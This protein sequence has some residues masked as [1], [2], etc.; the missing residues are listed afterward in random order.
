MPKS[1]T[2][3]TERNGVVGKECSKCFQWKTLEE[4]HRKRGGLGGRSV[5][6]KNCYKKHYRANREY[7]SQKHL[8]NKESINER[9]KKY[10]KASREYWIKRYQDNKDRILSLNKQWRKVNQ[11]K[12]REL[13]R[14]WYSENKEK[15][16]IT[17]Q[18][19]RARKKSLPNSWTNEDREFTLE[20]FGDSCCLT[21]E[22]EDIHF[23]HV[24]PLSIGHG[25]TIVGNMVPLR[26]DLNRSKGNKNIFEWFYE[27]KDQHNLSQ[28]KFDRLI[29]YL[30]D[31]NEMTVE[32]YKD[33]VYWCH[34]NP[35]VT[36]STQSC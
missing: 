32:E 18:K 8:D 10:Y 20:Y 12:H 29:E 35:N 22:N 14:K 27:V 21:G 7:W 5:S 6:C 25:G 15:K 23:D 16:V 34:E 24:I 11:E 17:E 9:H 3:L 30:A 28:E 2:K 31:I 19:R 26:A 33:Y 36:N 4:F 1:K 13:S